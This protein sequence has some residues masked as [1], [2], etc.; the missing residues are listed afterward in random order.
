MPR[1]AVASFFA[2]FARAAEA[3]PRF[4]HIPRHRTSP[5]HIA[6][7]QRHRGNQK[8]FG[9]DVHS[10]LDELFRLGVTQFKGNYPDVFGAASAMLMMVV[11]LLHDV[12]GAYAM[13]DILKTPEGLATCDWTFRALVAMSMAAVT[14][15]NITDRFGE[16]LTACWKN[17]LS[18]VG[19]MP[20]KN[21]SE[22]VSGCQLAFD[23][24]S[25]FHGTVLLTIF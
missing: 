25:E 1:N 12:L 24:E 3:L 9:M 19:G 14:A 10:F 7:R 17:V 20:P 11:V 23:C 2:K 16:A 18:T 8:S 22:T 4:S 6:H 21:S 13:E 15:G 5:S